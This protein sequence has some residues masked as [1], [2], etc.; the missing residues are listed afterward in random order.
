MATRELQRILIAEDDPSVL[1]MTRLRLQHEG[2]EVVVAVNG[3]EAVAKATTDP[4]IRLVLLD[5]RMPKLNGLEVCQRLKDRPETSAIPI[6]VFTASSI[7][8]QRLTDQCIEV[9]VS[10]WL[11]KPFRSEELL[12]R[13][14][15]ALEKGGGKHG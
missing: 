11:K 6:I 5:L 10:D 14:R 7:S 3:E 8:W 9:G 2:F 4:T 13:I 1:K 15:R 12:M